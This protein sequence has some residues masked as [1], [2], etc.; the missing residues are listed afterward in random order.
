MKRLAL[1]IVA[2]TLLLSCL[3]SVGEEKDSLKGLPGVRVLVEGLNKDTKS[4]GITRESLKT[5]AELELRR[6][7]IR[8]LAEEEGRKIKGNPFVYIDLHLLVLSN[9]A[10]AI[11]NLKVEF[12]PGCKALLE[13]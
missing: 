5:T 9:E 3:V 11:Y 13:L 2:I 6:A 8:V 10:D 12:L 4:L 1:L 7:G